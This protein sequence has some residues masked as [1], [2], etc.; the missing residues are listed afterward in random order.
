MGD[1]KYMVTYK[2]FT[3]LWGHNI[4]K[5][6]IKKKLWFIV[7]DGGKF[8]YVEKLIMFI[9]IKKFVDNLIKDREKNNNICGLD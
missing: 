7:L 2:Q 8:D 5:I 1:R 3:A 4:C 6:K 9:F